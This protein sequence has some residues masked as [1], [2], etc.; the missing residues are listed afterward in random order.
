LTQRVILSLSH[1]TK[2]F[3]KPKTS[4]GKRLISTHEITLQTLEEHYEKI[5]EEKKRYTLI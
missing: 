5:Q 4:F 2:E 3:N 1:I